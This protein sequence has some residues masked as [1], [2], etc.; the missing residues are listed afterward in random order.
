MVDPWYYPVNI[1]KIECHLSDESRITLMA[2][3]FGSGT[4]SMPKIGL[5]TGRQTGPSSPF[6]VASKPHLIWMNRNFSATAAF[7]LPVG[8]LE[9]CCPKNWGK[10]NERVCTGFSGPS[11]TD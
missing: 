2:V 11:L 6:F 4:S 10:L 5:D 1:R 7:S 3:I 8:L 9:I